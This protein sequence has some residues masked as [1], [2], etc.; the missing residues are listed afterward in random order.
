MV[1]MFRSAREAC[2]PGR[3]DGLLGLERVAP[4]RRPLRIMLHYA[5]R[6]ADRLG[7]AGGAT[8][9]C[10]ASRVATSN[11]SS[12]EQ[13]TAE[14]ESLACFA[15]ALVLLDD[16]RE[17]LEDLVLLSAWQLGDLVED[18]LK[19]AY[20]PWAALL[21]GLIAEDVFDAYSERLG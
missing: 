4:A 9:A 10:S 16:G 21:D 5:R 12:T 7:R 13:R 3:S 15:L 18:A 11:P 2:G 19:L 6:R 17:K 8:V 14:Q 1:V 20:G